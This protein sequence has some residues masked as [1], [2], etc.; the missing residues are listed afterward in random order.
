MGQDQD[1][2]NMLGLKD[3]ARDLVA[4]GVTIAIM[5]FRDAANQDH[6]LTPAQMVELVNK[7]KTAA[8]SIY[9]KSWELKAMNPIPQDYT[10]DSYWS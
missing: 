8:S 1:Q 3:T 4:A 2:I 10:D 9:Q 7:A 5:P 6:M